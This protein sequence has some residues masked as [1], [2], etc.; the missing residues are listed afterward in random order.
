MRVL[1]NCVGRRRTAA[2]LRQQD[3]ASRI[4]VSRQSLSVLEAGRSVPSTALALRL[5]RELGCQVED[6]FWTD[7]R[8]ASLSVE[9]APDHEPATA[10]PDKKVRRARL[11]E[12]P[13]ADNARV[14]VASVDGKWVAHRLTGVDSAPFHAAA[15]GLVLGT[16]GDKKGSARVALLE[17]ARAAGD[18]LLCAGCA[19]AFGILAARASAGRAAARVR[20]LERSSSAALD[21]L[22]RGLIHVG[23]AHLYDEEAQEFN[24]PFV[25]RRLPGRSMLIFNLGRWEAGLVVAAGNPRR[26]RGVRDLV[27]PEVSFV[28]RQPGAAARDLVDRLLRQ[29]GL[30]ERPRAVMTAHGHAEVARMVALGLADAGVA[31]PSM[32]R[33]HGLDFVPLAE[34]RFDLILSKEASA[35]ARVVRLLE[36][37]AGRPFRREM[38]SLGGHVA[39]DAGQLIADTSLLPPRDR[40]RGSQR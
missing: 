39:R 10:E 2:G 8:D 22:A 4:G 31:L 38:E 21:L 9:L 29:E 35:D 6:L 18:T 7:D 30:R 13:V 24:V 14:V 25:Q 17:D 3:L 33:A 36:T 5:A 15:D 23:G 37:L 16:G 1:R 26:I 34:E 40:D 11:V 28:Q 32:A 12:T 20:W 19:P 27:R